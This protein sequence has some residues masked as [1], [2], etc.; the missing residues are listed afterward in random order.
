[1]PL[2]LFR[3]GDHYVLMFDLPGADPGS[4]DV[5]AQDKTLTVTAHRSSHEGSNVQWVAHERPTGTYARQLVLG[6]DADLDRIDA[7]FTDGVL[8]LTIPVAEESKPRKIEVTHGSASAMP[9]GSAGSGGPAGQ[10]EVT[11]GSSGETS[12]S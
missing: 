5:S 6:R 8:T 3:T 9:A 7:T 2:D 1:M 10:S 4:I 12:G 11:S